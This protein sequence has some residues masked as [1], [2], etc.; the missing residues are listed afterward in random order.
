[1]G[2]TD[3]GD[4]LGAAIR[5]RRARNLGLPPDPRDIVGLSILTEWEKRII[6]PV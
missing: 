1:V 4:S 2:D 6:E 3:L 5:L